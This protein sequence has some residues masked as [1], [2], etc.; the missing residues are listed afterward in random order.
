MA[1]IPAATSGALSMLPAVSWPTALG[2][3]AGMGALQQF[4][5]FVTPKNAYRAGRALVK[6]KRSGPGSRTYTKSTKKRPARRAKPT[7]K[8]KRLRKKVDKI[9]KAVNA[10]TGTVTVKRR[11]TGVITSNI[12]QQ[13]SNT[14][15]MNTLTQ[16]EANPCAEL[17]YYDPN[18]P[19]TLQNP[20]F[21]TGSFSKELNIV[22]S[23][24]VLHLK[25]NSTGNVNLKV[26]LA[27]PRDD[28]STTPN[29]AWDI[30]DSDS[31]T[32]IDKTDIG[33]LPS[34]HQSFLALWSLKSLYDGKMLPGT[35]RVF[36]HYEKGFQYNPAVADSQTDAYQR[37]NKAF[38]FYVIQSG[39]LAHDSTTST[40]VGRANSALDWE[41]CRYWKV[42]YPAG[43]NIRYSS[44]G[45][46]YG[47][48]VAAE[49]AQ[50]PVSGIV[51]QST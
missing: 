3:A 8:S 30:A 34:D 45:N 33:S 26:Y 10:D 7:T 31:P 25:N 40:I 41:M 4:R 39:D 5:K 9:A 6:F 11:T 16:I 15:D 27:K 38:A 43:V 19:G 22:S 36:K 20:A 23:G 29:Q 37:Q 42:V 12:N 46:V 2:A 48:I 1:L 35:S 47:S 18:T 21:T 51:A 32:T 14:F 50:K 13:N 28:T 49:E 24:A 44:I 17:Y